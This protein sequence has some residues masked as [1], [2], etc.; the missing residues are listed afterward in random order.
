MIYKPP[1]IDPELAPPGYEEAKSASAKYFEERKLAEEKAKQEREAARLTVG[2]L[3]ELLKDVDD[4]L[5]VRTYDYEFGE[6]EDTFGII[7]VDDTLGLKL[8][9]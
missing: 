3:K 5:F 9:F 7:V 6:W 1:P 2:K 8:E 4:D